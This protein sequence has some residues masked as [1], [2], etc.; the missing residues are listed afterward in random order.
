MQ[1]DKE[2]LSKIYLLDDAHRY[3]L[4]VFINGLITQKEISKYHKQKNKTKSFFAL[5][6]THCLTA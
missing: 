2:L 6:D 1:E 4:T 5:Q 3:A